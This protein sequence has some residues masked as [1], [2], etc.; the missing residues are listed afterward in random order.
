VHLVCH[1]CISKQFAVL[2]HGFARR[3]ASLPDAVPWPVVVYI[4]TRTTFACHHR[5][6]EHK[7]KKAKATA[8]QPQPAETS[9][10][11]AAADQQP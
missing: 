4:R 8:S 9:R 3:P 6:A 11:P 5:V 1:Q 7:I 10:V 2:V